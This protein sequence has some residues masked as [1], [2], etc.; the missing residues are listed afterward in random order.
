MTDT[1]RVIDWK[2][3]KE[4]MEGKL[5]KDE[6]F[7]ENMED[8]TDYLLATGKGAGQLGRMEHRFVK[9][10]ETKNLRDSEFSRMSQSY[11]QKR[12]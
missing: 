2:T 5:F 10:S 6:F 12:T 7:Y 9:P 11:L 3:S 4:P 8:P 1:A